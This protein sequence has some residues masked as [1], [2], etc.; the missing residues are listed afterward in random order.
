MSA[1]AKLRKSSDDLIDPFD[2]MWRDRGLPGSGKA[3]WK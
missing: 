1:R 3:I 2:A